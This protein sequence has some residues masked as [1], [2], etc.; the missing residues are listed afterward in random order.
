VTARRRLE[1]QYRQAQKMEAVGQLASGIAHDFNNLLT[2]ING[3]ADLLLQSLPP[4][5]SSQELLEEIRRAG[6]R[7]AGLTR[8]L[9]AFGRRQVLAP[10]V[11]DLNAVAA[12]TE[13]MLRRVIG[14]DVRLATVPGPGL[15]PVRA[16]PGQVEQVLLN[17]AVNARDAMPTG[18]RLTIETR[19]VEL[20][21]EYALAHAGA[22]PGPHVLLAV[23]DTGCGMTDEVKARIFEPFFTTKGP[24]RG[25]GLGLATVYGIVT[26]SGGHLGVDSEA[27]AGTTFRVYLPRAEGPVGEPK[28]GSGAPAPRRGAETVLLVEDD[29]A[30][31]ALN[32]H[33]L[34]GCGYTVVEA[35]D[36]DEAWRAAVRHAGGPIHLLV[37]D[38]V[39]PGQGGRALA[40]RLLERHPG[41]KV[42]Y[43][44]GYTDDAVVRHGVLREAMNFLQK[45]FTPTALAHRVREVL[46][47]G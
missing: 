16:D 17:L 40:E 42:L 18:G 14:E 36:G 24:G 7:A 34:A 3:Y 33:V 12:D 47:R 21:D 5:D 41:L 19:N 22:H 30:V 4:A 9:L 15:W 26:Q 32:R 44:S 31:R 27:G 11:L 10:R 46:D 37:T 28:A 38:V 45:P 39:M 6:E 23:S 20:D 2:V 8:Q 43:V 13:A 29:P 25:T 35:G 1:E